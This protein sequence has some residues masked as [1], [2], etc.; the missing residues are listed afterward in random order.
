[1]WDDM[2]AYAFLEMFL[3]TY[4]IAKAKSNLVLYLSEGLFNFNSFK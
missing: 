2:A 4:H 1:M 3:N